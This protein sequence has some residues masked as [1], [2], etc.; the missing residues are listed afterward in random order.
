MITCSSK[1]DRWVGFG[2]SPE[3]EQTVANPR[4]ESPRVPLYVR[5][6]LGFE[7]LGGNRLLGSGAIHKQGGIPVLIG[8]VPFTLFTHRLA[9]RKSESR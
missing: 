4:V 7:H 1:F 3:A 8:E 9:A 5:M 2:L 6:N